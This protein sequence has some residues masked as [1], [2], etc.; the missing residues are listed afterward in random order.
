MISI[1]FHSKEDKFYIG[2]YVG[3]GEYEFKEIQET[4]SK[5]LRKS[6]SDN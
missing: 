4:S 6:L 3:Q 1:V 2:G 5:A